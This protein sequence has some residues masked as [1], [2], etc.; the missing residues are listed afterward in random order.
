MLGGFLGRPGRK[1]GPPQL[2]LASEKSDDEMPG[3]VSRRRSAMGAPSQSIASL[4]HGQRLTQ[5]DVASLCSDPTAEARALV[6]RKLGQQADELV[7]EGHTKLVAAILGLLV[8]DVETEVRRSLAEAMATSPNLPV[9]VAN[10]LANDQIEI[11]RHILQSSPVLRD[12]DLIRIVRTSAMQYSLAVAARE[13][14][15][16]QLSEA[17]VDTGHQPVVAR[18][19]EN[20]KAAIS[21]STYARV[22]EDFGD[23]AEV[24]ERLVRRIEL[25]QELVDR[26]T[27]SIGQTIE[28]RLVK[29]NSADAATA[30]DLIRTA[31]Q[32]ATITR[33]AR[34]C[35]E[36]SL[37]R[38]LR[39]RFDAGELDQQEVLRILNSGDIACFET[40]M[41][42]MATVSAKRVRR[43]LYHEDRKHLMALCAVAEFST[44]HFVK[45]YLAIDVAEDVLATRG[46]QKAYSGEALSRLR[47]QY[48]ALAGDPEALA[49][50]LDGL[51]Q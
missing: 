41:A 34:D 13:N 35:N 32:N 12:E 1:D 6:A 14:I 17:L 39:E 10:Q 5:A 2:P 27:S 33:M 45:L 28:A 7:E 4:E 42:I 50:L 30:K 24:R 15:G 31:T 25:P 9:A 23:N 26:L 47:A 21:K 46:R 3:A 36:E 48:E 20:Q 40:A 29:S 19:L 16:E 38:H 8:K 22:I 18:L 44:S 11:A 51:A 37:R 49:D 43:L